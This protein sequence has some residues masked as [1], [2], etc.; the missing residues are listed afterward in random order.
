MLQIA[1]CDDDQRT[2]NDL[3]KDIAGYAKRHDVHLDIDK[4]EHAKELREEI[5]GEGNIRY[6]SWICLCQRSTE[7]NL[8][9]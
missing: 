3:E 4:F 6:I 5:E 7:W 9:R 2:L 8:G 1:L